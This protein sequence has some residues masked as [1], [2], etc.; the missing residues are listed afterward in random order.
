MNALSER[1]LL[2]YLGQEFHGSFSHFNIFFLASDVKDL[3][4]FLVG[5]WLR[6]DDQGTI[7]Q[8]DWKTV[9]RQIIGSSNFGD[10]SV[11]GH[12]D[13]WSLIRFKSSVEE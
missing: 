10:S 9:R 6:A 2:T 4:D 7:K 3:A 1:A 13:N 8:I 5:V 12:H 11:G